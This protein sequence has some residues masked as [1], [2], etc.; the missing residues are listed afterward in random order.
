MIGSFLKSVMGVNNYP[1]PIQAPT[2]FQERKK[3]IDGSYA[4]K[5]GSKTERRLKRTYRATDRK[6]LFLF[7]LFLFFEKLPFTLSLCHQSIIQSIQLYCQVPN[8]QGMCHVGGHTLL[9]TH[10]NHDTKDIATT[11]I[12]FKQREE[13]S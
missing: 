6:R 13:L 9:H 5:T 1:T 10:T 8:A 3:V 4:A 11:V 7:V 12:T 2:H